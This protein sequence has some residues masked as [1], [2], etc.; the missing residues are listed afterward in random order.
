MSTFGIRNNRSDSRPTSTVPSTEAF[1][2]SQNLI[3]GFSIK[4]AVV[5]NLSRLWLKNSS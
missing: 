2:K 4:K 1:S 5:T 3:C